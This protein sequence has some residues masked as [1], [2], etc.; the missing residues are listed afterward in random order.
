MTKLDR[1]D[2]QILKILSGNGRITK[3]ELARQVCLSVS[4]TWERVKRL[5]SIGLIKGYRAQVDW[6]RV[7]SSCTVIVQVSLDRHTAQEM[8]RFEQ[9]ISELPEITQCYATGGGVDYFMHVRA[10]DIDHYQRLIDGL[11]Q[12]NIGIDRYY[13][14]IVT[15]N[16]KTAGALPAQV[17]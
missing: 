5:E 1:Y 7:F 10:S 11:L 4:P 2:L 8:Q 9:R 15:K 17:L 3:S 16:I 13:T 14:Y 6:E 12:E